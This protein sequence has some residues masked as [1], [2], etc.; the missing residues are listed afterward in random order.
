MQSQDAA[1]GSGMSYAHVD[2]DEAGEQ[3]WG[4]QA[5]CDGSVELAIVLLKILAAWDAA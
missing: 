3:H 1:H 5:L 2:V 4:Q